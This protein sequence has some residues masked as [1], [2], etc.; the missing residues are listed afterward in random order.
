MTYKVLQEYLYQATC[1]SL[2]LTYIHTLGVAANKNFGG[3]MGWK[4]LRE[5]I[6]E[7]RLWITASVCPIV[8]GLEA[9]NTRS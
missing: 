7:F 6:V 3:I 2:T 5:E 1:Y 9:V 8:P 4:G